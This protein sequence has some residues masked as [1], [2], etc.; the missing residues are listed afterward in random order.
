MVLREVDEAAPD[1]NATDSSSDPSSPASTD[2][3]N[4]P[5]H[6]DTP[7]IVLPDGR[8]LPIW[9][10]PAVKHLIEKH[11]KYP[12][13]FTPIP[14]YAKLLGWT[15]FIRDAAV[16][17][18]VNRTQLYIARPLDP[19]EVNAETYYASMLYKYMYKSEA[20][21]VVSFLALAA[22]RSNAASTRPGLITPYAKKYMGDFVG[23]WYITFT[24]Y[25]IYGLVGRLQGQLIGAL[26]GGNKMRQVAENDPNIKDLR[27]DLSKFRQWNEV[28]ILRKI[29]RRKEGS[30]ESIFPTTEELMKHSMEHRRHEAGE[31][32]KM[33]D[34]GALEES[35]ADHSKSDIANLSQWSNKGPYPPPGEPPSPSRDPLE[36]IIP[37]SSSRY[38]DSPPSG[39]A[40][41]G[42]STWDR[43][44]RERM[45]AENNRNSNLASESRSGLK[46]TFS[47]GDRERQLAQAEAQ[48]DFDARLER[49][50]SGQ[51]GWG[52]R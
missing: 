45:Q 20:M 2:T 15:E 41:P 3:F 38:V 5:G 23:D 19:I 31:G 34:E 51:R 39:R 27:R 47:E 24:R 32:E 1:L 43:I 4:E 50:R 52:S 49:E 6:V 35:A 25:G 44:R 14:I 22:L 21:G 37:P 10:V 40:N 9:T 16:V 29:Q 11:P 13:P 18:Q 7:K 26:L 30:K 12:N 48:K 17:A 28:E 8:S 36:D 46:F 42:E 33:G